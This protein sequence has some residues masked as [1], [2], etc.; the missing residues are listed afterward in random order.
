MSRYYWFQLVA[1]S[2]YKH[3]YFV[4]QEGNMIWSWYKNTI[5]FLFGNILLNRRTTVHT[6]STLSLVEKEV[7]SI[8]LNTKGYRKKDH[9]APLCVFASR[10]RVCRTSLAMRTFLW[11]VDRRSSATKTTWCWMRA[12]RRQVLSSFSCRYFTLPS[13]VHTLLSS[14]PSCS[15][16]LFFFVCAVF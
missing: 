8:D 16:L 5:H 1:S 3:I 13:Y 9:W 10:C 15:E 12:V 14:F 7:C 2:L 4:I 11:R 6:V